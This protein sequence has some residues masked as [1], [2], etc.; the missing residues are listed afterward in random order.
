VPIRAQP[1]MAGTA[2]GTPVKGNPRRKSG[3]RL[4][5]RR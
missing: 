3:R 1:Q 5:V 4:S 2:S